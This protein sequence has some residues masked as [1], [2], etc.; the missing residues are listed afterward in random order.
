MWT[1][2]DTLAEFLASIELER[3]VVQAHEAVGLEFNIVWNNCRVQ[4]GGSSAGNLR[5]DFKEVRGPNGTFCSYQTCCTRSL[6]IRKD[7]S[8][9]IA[10]CVCPG[11]KPSINNLLPVV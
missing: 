2:V 6:R 3:V 10:L 5:M 8:C 4:C 9:T 7:S 1:H 11:M